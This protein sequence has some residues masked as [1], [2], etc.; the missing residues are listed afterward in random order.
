M[1]T[2]ILWLSFAMH[3]NFICLSLLL[4]T[5]SLKDQYSSSFS[6]HFFTRAF[7]GNIEECQTRSFRLLVFDGH[8]QLRLASK[9]L[10]NF[11]NHNG[12]PRLDT[13]DTLKS[14]S[15]RFPSHVRSPGNPYFRIVDSPQCRV[16]IR[17]LIRLARI[18][19]KCISP[20]VNLITQPTLPIWRNR[21]LT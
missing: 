7:L 10:G 4:Q 8:R 12:L 5:K 21:D 3:I 17:P 11:D 16:K 15:H 6:F 2:A 1:I 9:A 20:C 19:K 18:T 13:L 14:K